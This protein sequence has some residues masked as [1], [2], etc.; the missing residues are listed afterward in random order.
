LDKTNNG[1]DNTTQ[2]AT[3]SSQITTEV[4][5]PVSTDNVTVNRPE[6]VALK[7]AKN[8]AKKSM[9]ISWKKMAVNG[10]EVQIALN[11]KFTKSKKTYNSAS[12][13]ITIKKLKKKKTY[14]VRVR[15]YNKDGSNKLYGSW[16]KIKKVKIKK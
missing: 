14:Y 7:S 8:N 12:T 13:T 2:Q 16:S 1:G 15:A 4:I 5:Q 3:D 10:Y 9:K 6:K 11:K